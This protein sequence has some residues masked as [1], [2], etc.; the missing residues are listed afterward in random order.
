M[1]ATALMWAQWNTLMQL[2]LLSV[3]VL[4][5]EVAQ[6]ALPESAG[7]RTPVLAT[8]TAGFVVNRVLTRLFSEV[9]ALLDDGAYV[10]TVTSSDDEL[11][12]D[13]LHQFYKM[14]PISRHITCAASSG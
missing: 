2:T 14:K 6:T 4:G 12:L 7:P 8:D 5:A 3:L 11:E 9:L 10:A 13:E 1:D